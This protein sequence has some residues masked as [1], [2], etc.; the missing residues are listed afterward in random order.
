M[1]ITRLSVLVHISFIVSLGL[2]FSQ[3]RMILLFD[4]SCKSGNLSRFLHTAGEEK[5]VGERNSWT[6]GYGALPW[7]LT[8]KPSIQPKDPT[9]QGT[10]L[11]EAVGRYVLGKKKSY[12]S[13]NPIEFSVQVQ[14]FTVQSQS[15]KWEIRL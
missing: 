14:G 7:G 9:A 11:K 1:V 8:P 15:K 4:P 6:L 13:K 3:R 10:S 2:G 5:R 12:S